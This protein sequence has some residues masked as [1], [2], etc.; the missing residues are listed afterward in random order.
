MG[1]APATPGSRHKLF[2]SCRKQQRCAKKNH[3]IA[4]IFPQQSFLE[5][6]ALDRVKV[7]LRRRRNVFAQRCGDTFHSERGHELEAIFWS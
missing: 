4:A 7:D 2:R 6:C 1:I 3:P 5:R